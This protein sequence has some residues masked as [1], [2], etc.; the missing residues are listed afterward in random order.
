MQFITLRPAVVMVGMDGKP[1]LIKSKES[2]D[3]VMKNEITPD[4]LKQFV[5]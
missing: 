4:F 5:L 2:V 3:D 1:H